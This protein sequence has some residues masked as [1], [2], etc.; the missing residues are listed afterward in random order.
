MIKAQDYP[1]I[2]QS[3]GIDISNLGCIMLDTD[4][5][6]IS[7]IIRNQDLYFKEDEPDSHT[8][9]AVSENEPH[10][11]LLYGLLQPGPELKDHVDLLLHDWQPGEI[12]IEKVGFFYS[13]DPKHPDFITIIAEVLVTPEL[14]DGNGRMRMLPHINT[15]PTYKPHITLAY[16]KASSDWQNYV[17]ALNERYAG[18]T[19]GYKGVNYGD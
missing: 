15:F 12:I 19:V 11:T 14:L 8:Q 1:G 6:E 18:Q 9:G 2:Y 3:L 5:I 17:N 13:N 4:K 7:T 16:V 10:V